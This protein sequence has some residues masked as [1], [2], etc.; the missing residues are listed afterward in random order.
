MQNQ[1]LL[2][3]LFIAFF[4]LVVASVIG[5]AIAE[6]RV[7]T[8]GEEMLASDGYQSNQLIPDEIQDSSPSK[9][10]LSIEDGSG[11]PFGTDYGTILVMDCSGNIIE[12]HSGVESASWDTD[13]GV[14]TLETSINYGTVYL[15]LEY[16]NPAIF[17]TQHFCVMCLFSGPGA[18]FTFIA[19]V[20]VVR[21][22]DK[23]NMILEGN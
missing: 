6:G 20:R 4:S 7:I 11:W 21:N 2:Y 15:V 22:E 3:S 1:E 19:L 10:S 9:C 5:L 16:D 17:N 13:T 12:K 18:L 14:F 8:R 23:V